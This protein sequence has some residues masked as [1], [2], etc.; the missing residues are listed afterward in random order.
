MPAIAVLVENM[1]EHQLER[2]RNAL[3]G[4]ELLYGEDLTGDEVRRA[5]IVAG[6]R[7]WAEKAVLD[8]A[9]RCKWVQTW[10]AGVDRLPLGQMLERGIVVTT[11]SGVHAYPISETIFAMLLALTRNLHVYIRNQLKRT[12]DRGGLRLEMHGKTIGI[13]GVGDIGEET[14]RIAKA[15]GMTV[16]GVRRSALPSP[17]VDRMVGPGAL[18]EVLPLCDYVVVTVPATPETRHM[19]D[20]PEFSA[21]KPGAFFVNI[22]RGAT[23]RTEALLAALRSGRL[24]GA[25]LDVFEEEP[26]PPDHP[27][28]QM[29]NV[30]ITP[31]SSGFTEH[32]NDRALDIFVENAAAY[33]AG[34]PLPLN[35]VEASKL[36]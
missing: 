5:E 32:Y 13:V 34:K 20:E 14:A 3:P 21:M 24:A 22:G 26:L 17:H 30:I 10:S 29:D 6:W 31:H 8:P 33:L 1:K 28:W 4:W 7:E 9:S 12:W 15:F 16:I 36:Y 35:V 27:L 2:I 19:F 11:A 25:G 23:V 18:R